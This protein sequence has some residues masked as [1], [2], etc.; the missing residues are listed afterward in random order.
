L[1]SATAERQPLCRIAGEDDG[2]SRHFLA[3]ILELS[4]YRVAFGDAVE[5]EKADVVLAPS[6]AALPEDGEAPVVRLRS[7]IAR[8]HADDDSIYR[9]D[10]A[11]LL[12]E[13]ERHRAGGRA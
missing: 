7:A 2:W 8:Q 6:G 10:R 11:G 4:G 3:P 12:L 9:Y 13:L 1:A 5:G